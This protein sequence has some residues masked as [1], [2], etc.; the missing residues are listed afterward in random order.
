MEAAVFALVFV[1]ALVAYVI[2]SVRTGLAEDALWSRQQALTG[3]GVRLGRSAVARAAARPD[4]LALPRAPERLPV[5]VAP[6]QTRLRGE[7]V[8]GRASA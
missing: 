5:A 8:Q 1:L 4:L 2:L 7:E 6:P 3:H